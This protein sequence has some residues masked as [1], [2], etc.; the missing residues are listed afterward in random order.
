MVLHLRNGGD[1]TRQLIYTLIILK[2]TI[3]EV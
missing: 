2:S 3:A 1:Q